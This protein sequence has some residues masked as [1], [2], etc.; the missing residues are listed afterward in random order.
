MTI[1]SIEALAAC[2]DFKGPTQPLVGVVVEVSAT[3][4]VVA[5]AVERSA[6]TAK[7]QTTAFIGGT[8]TC[9]GT[10]QL[11]E[12][13]PVPPTEKAPSTPTTLERRTQCPL[14]FKTPAT[15]D[16]NPTPSTHPIVN[17]EA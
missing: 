2:N 5:Q 15:P 14:K 13:C 3:F 10:A 6:T 16:V 11:D 4:A 7:E 12:R 17:D 9:Y 1:G 8:G